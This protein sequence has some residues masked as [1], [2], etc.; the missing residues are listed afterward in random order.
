MGSSTEVKIYRT[1]KKVAKAVAREIYKITG[2]AARYDI[3]LS[4]G[5]TPKKLF[6]LLA[7]KYKDKL[8][9]HRIHFWWADERC[10]ATDDNESNFRLANVLLFSKVPVPPENIHR[11]RGEND[12]E[13][14]AL[15]YAEEIEKNLNSGNPVFDIVLLGM[16]SDGHTASIF[17][18][19]L[20]LVN[21]KKICAATQHPGTGQYRV[22]LTGSVIKNSKKIFIM[23]TGENKSDRISEIMNNEEEAKLL[24]AYYLEPNN[25]T[26]IWFLDEPAAIKI[27]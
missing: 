10:V 17:P 8:P 11:I 2:D 19:R 26:L 21:E 1:P 23:V 25:G 22:T 7:E 3:A 5:N 12:P 16:G 4:G 27:S 18:G 13:S 15:R 14:E 20:E 6:R 24:P 9:W